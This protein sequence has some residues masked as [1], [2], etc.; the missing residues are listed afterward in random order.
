MV[1]TVTM[2]SLSPSCVVSR[3]SW[4][5]GVSNVIDCQVGTDLSWDSVERHLLI[6]FS[7]SVERH[8]LIDFSTG[9]FDHIDIAWCGVTDK[10]PTCLKP[11]SD[12][13]IFLLV[14]LS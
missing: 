1:S 9:V 5:T 8:L 6:D 10:W 14:S 12:Y 11:D 2:T 4:L 7:D 13:Q 3:W